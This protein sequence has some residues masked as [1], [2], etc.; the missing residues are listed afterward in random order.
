MS[1]LETNGIAFQLASDPMA[2]LPLVTGVAIVTIDGDV[3]IDGI[4]APRDTD[5]SVTCAAVDTH[6]T[7]IF[8]GT[9]KGAIYHVKPGSAP[10][11]LAT[12]ARKWIEH[13]LA[14]PDG[15][16]II[17]YGKTA[18]RFS[19]DGTLLAEWSHTSAITGLAL[20]PKFKRFAC[21]HFNGVSLWWLTDVKAQVNLLTWAGIHTGV[22]WSPCSKFIVSMMQDNALHGWRIMDKSNMRMA[23]YPARCKSVAWTADGKYLATSGAP[24][25][26]CWPFSSKDGPMGKAPLEM[27]PE[28]NAFTT[29]VACHPAR[30]IIAAGYEDGRVLMFRVND[31]AD[32]PVADVND[33]AVSALAFSHDGNSLAFARTDGSAGY[34]QI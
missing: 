16:C 19:A 6:G 34:I 31:Q 7:Q 24:P 32:I 22:T 2:V 25:V 8:M 10:I 1:L 4:L 27:P 11:L 9:E 33:S 26:V 14:L 5:L 23:G 20:E 30:N 13:I 29:T 12:V 17:A 3:Y 28:N 21:S 18:A 15:G